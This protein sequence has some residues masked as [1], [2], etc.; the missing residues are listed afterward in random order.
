MQVLAESWRHVCGF[1]TK[2]KSYQSFIKIIHRRA[3]FHQFNHK[4]AGPTA[5]SWRPGD[6]CTS[7]SLTTPNHVRLSGA[8]FH[9]IDTKPF[10]SSYSEHNGLMDLFLSVSPKV[11]LVL[12]T[13]R[14]V[15]PHG[16]R[17]A[18]LDDFISDTLAFWG[19]ITFSHWIHVRASSFLPKN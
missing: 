1:A 14:H 3:S 5:K 11:R 2:K 8:D 4:P 18:F 16:V 9:C 6:D 12:P 19:R 10:S 15:E 17:Q 13:K 7:P